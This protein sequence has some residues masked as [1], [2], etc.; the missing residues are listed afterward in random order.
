MD[1]ADQRTFKSVIFLA[2]RRY[3]TCTYSCGGIDR[4][5]ALNALKHAKFLDKWILDKKSLLRDAFDLS[6]TLFNNNSM[7]YSKINEVR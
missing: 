3:H 7:I 4:L 2:L 6:A 1:F 5:W